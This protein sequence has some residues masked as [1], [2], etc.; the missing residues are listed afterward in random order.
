MV[1][2]SDNRNMSGPTTSS[3]VPTPTE[4]RQRA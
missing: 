3:G 1:A 4:A 2:A